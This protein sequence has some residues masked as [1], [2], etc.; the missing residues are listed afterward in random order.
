MAAWPRLE[1]LTHFRWSRCVLCRTLHRKNIASPKQGKAHSYPMKMNI[2]LF[3]CDR[4]QYKNKWTFLFLVAMLQKFRVISWD[5]LIRKKSSPFEWNRFKFKSVSLVNSAQTAWKSCGKYGILNVCTRKYCDLMP[6]FFSLQGGCG[7]KQIPFRPLLPPSERGQNSHASVSG[8]PYLYFFIAL[9]RRNS[10]P[11][12]MQGKRHYC[13]TS[14][15]PAHSRHTATT[16]IIK[17]ILG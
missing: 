14:P 9:F 4:L 12:R 7:E 6:I 17:H 16:Y 2:R 1:I 11:A 5:D 10:I 3:F 8:Q 13:L 15:Y